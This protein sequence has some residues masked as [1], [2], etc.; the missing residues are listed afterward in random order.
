M[1]RRKSKRRQNA[2]TNRKINGRI[3]KKLVGLFIIVVLALVGLALRIT[4][5]N[6][7][8]G[9]RYKRQV[10]SQTQQQYDSRIIP[11]KRGE[12]R[13]RNGT[14]LATSEK[15]YNV[16]L[17][18]KVVN[19]SIKIKGEATQRY[20]EPTV[21]A[22][23][24]VLGLEE[25]EIRSRL[26]NEE[27]KNSQY[28]VLIKQ[29]SITDK[30]KFEA[31]LDVKSE[32]NEGLS[33][34]EKAERQRV[35]GVWFE[36]DYLR[37]YPMNS[38]ASDLIGFTYD[39]TSADWGIE[40]YYSSVLNGINGRQFGYFN[41]DA[42]VEQTIIDPVDGKN[43]I[44]TIDTN[45]QQIIRKALEKYQNEM[46]NGPDGAKGAKNVG[47]VA[48]NPNTGEILGM[49]SSDWYDLN[50]PRDLSSFYTPEEIEAMDDEARLNALFEIWRNYCI[51]D[52]YEPGSTFK[53]MTVA[54]ALESG[55]ITEDDTFYCGGFKKVGG[56]PIKCAIYPNGHGTETL[57][58]TLKY[59]C[60]VAMMDIGE[61][62]GAETFLKY[63]KLFNFGSYTGID[64]PGEGSGILHSL[65]GLGSTE[66]GTA[67]FGQGF[68]STMIQEIAAF[69]SVINGGVYYKPHV[70]NT[71]T[72]SSG[73]VVENTEPV[74]VRQVVSQEVSDEVRGYL[75]TVME[76]GG[77][78]AKANVSGY[79][80]G[81][82]TGTAQ[83]IPRVDRKYLVSFI[84]FAPL[85][86]P[87]VVL[88]VVVDEPNTDVQ[89]NSIYAQNIYKDIMAELMPYMNIFP[90]DP[91]KVEDLEVD[92]SLAGSNAEGV[93]DD[94]VPNPP[95]DENVDENGNQIGES[96]DML[97]DGITNSEAAI[98]NE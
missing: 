33:K 44:S 66:L 47:V 35:K 87:Q 10:L 69:S 97:S 81:G 25:S 38:L 79:T 95:E 53:P 83:K 88:Y 23:V 49:D 26:E 64:L 91:S 75:G 4:Y 52:A 27:T 50:N 74:V 30:K 51:S 68:T 1:S 11:F 94:N 28:Q 96:N 9:E 12:I 7:T 19:S 93:A 86:N 8:D 62:M 6:A 89:A 85:E 3:S 41:S 54:A 56:I 67:S 20:L 78:G 77:T 21:K 48:M 76:P 24:E 71:I 37:V 70:V 40:G 43:V 34:E 58:E 82:K 13:D 36:E 65:D 5:I 29:L 60:N 14:I 46:A 55:S 98:T 42:D 17:D 72:D 2:I 22:L 63:Q 31:Y 80:M 57:S 90:T 61:A 59:S 32:E 84:G 15:V 45:I 39:G 18:C 92:D 16:I 73:A